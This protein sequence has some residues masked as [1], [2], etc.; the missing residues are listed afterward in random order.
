MTTMSRMSTSW[1]TVPFMVVLSAGVSAV[2]QG[3]SEFEEDEIANCQTEE[4]KGGLCGHALAAIARIEAAKSPLAAAEILET[5]S[6]T[7]ITHCFLDIEV[8]TATSPKTISGSNTLSVTSLINGLTQLTL[9]LQSNMVVDAATVND[10]AAGFTRSGNTI[11]INLGQTYNA[12]Q[13]FQAKVTYHGTPKNR[14]DF[15]GSTQY[16]FGT[17]NSSNIV[18]TLSQPYQAN[19]WWPCKENW[20]AADSPL[21][22]KFTLDFW[23]TVPNTM[24]AA[25]NGALQGTDTLSGNRLRFRWRESYPI[26][27]YLVSLA[28]TN[29]TKET[30]AYNYSG[31]SMPVEFYIFPESV[32]ESEPY[33]SNIVQAITTFSDP[34]IYGQYP[35]ITEKYGIAQFPWCCGMEHQ[36]ITSQGAYTSEDRNIHELSHQW[37]G[38]YV[39]CRTWHDVWLNEGFGTFSVALWAEKRPGGSYTN[40]LNY[41]LGRKP[42]TTGTGT[43]YRYDLSSSSTIFSTTYSYNKGAWVVHM[44]RHVLGDEKFFATLA[45][46]RNQ[47]GG[48][49]ADTENFRS[50][51]ELTAQLEPDSLNWFFNQWIYNAGYPHYRYGWEQEQIGTQNWVRLHIEQFQKTQV[52]SFPN[53]MK[54]PIDIT[55][56][57]AGG[58]R[59]H[60]VWNDATGSGTTVREWFLLPANG[61]VTSVQFDKNT[62]ILRPDP[63]ATA[64]YVDGPPKVIGSTPAPGQRLPAI[65]G[66]QSISI[67]F[68]EAVTCSDSDFTVTSSRTGSRPFALSYNP[69][70]YTATLQLVE[71]LTSEQTITV[72]IRDSIVSQ[73]AGAQLD[74]ELADPTNA[75]DLPS[76]EGL[77]GGSATLTFFLAVRGDFDGDNDVDLA[78]LNHL[79]ACTTGPDLG[80]VVTSCQDADFDGDN[81]VDQTDFGI[82]Q[83]CLAGPGIPPPP[84]CAN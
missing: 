81:D 12:G 34:N 8:Q 9:D 41:L 7:D 29:Y 49:G 5:Q 60:V 82:L 6:E 74:G 40:Y 50:L 20:G 33:L 44:L 79:L 32:A 67:R 75:A 22:D 76:G 4:G 70:D 57:T 45:A 72:Q 48:S 19:Y 38:D 14:T 21:D 78:D 11:V 30:Y 26:A 73:A 83:R 42:S 51:C 84:Q 28:A 46:Y 25:S 61:N 77:S 80:P 18:S 16:F 55:I 2:G 62:W 53:A 24:I 43:T 13:A 31:G 65:P 58:S 56:N 52:S 39:T 36:T 63:V 27:T 47:F 35:F 37:W 64:T 23:L 71:P 68:S 15:F 3:L 17:H 54:M 1:L 10:V 66:V 59:T 69:G